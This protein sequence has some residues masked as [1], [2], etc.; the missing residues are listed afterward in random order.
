MHAKENRK[1]DV[2]YNTT[3]VCPWDCAVCC[4][5]AV[6]VQKEGNL[7]QIRSENLK[8]LTTV[9]F[10]AAGGSIYDQASKHRQRFGQELDLAA[11]LRVID[12]LEGFDAKVDISGGDALSVTDNFALL[13][14]ASKRLGREKV[15]LTVTGAGS[16]RYPARV[17]AP[18]IGEY[19]FTFDAEAITDVALRPEGYALGNLRKAIAFVKE[20]VTT[21]A[22]TPLNKAI[23]HDEHLERLYSTLQRAGISKLL[24]MRL[25]PVGRGT[26]LEHE[27]PSAEEYRHAIG[28]LR[29]LEARYGGPKVKVQCALKHLVGA[30]ASSGGN[31]CDL[32]SESFGLMADGTLL[33]SP[34]AVG[35]TGKPLG[36]EWVLG[37]LAETPMSELL[38]TPKA[39][40]FRHR[41][42]ENFGH[43][44]IFSYR[45][46]NKANRFDRIF[47]RADPLYAASSLVRKEPKVVEG[48]AL[49]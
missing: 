36:E 48:P 7:I 23:L 28:L 9:P 31:P 37:N 29:E 19:N 13:E 1:I 39:Q 12:H 49:V 18:L 46:S 14:Y 43:C 26:L 16:T 40:Q 30:V 41:A 11:K 38:A 2:I 8:S 27:I 44:K 45:T 24:V 20:G 34:W 21:R 4:V 47:D 25:F 3:L 33:A 6:H 15:T 10:D 32:V 42:D 35:T 17:L 5:D 22:E